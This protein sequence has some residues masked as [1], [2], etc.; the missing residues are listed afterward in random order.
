MT[1][2]QVNLLAR[3]MDFDFNLE[4]DFI[5]VPR[6]YPLL[7]S[8]S[9]PKALGTY[10]FMGK[11]RKLETY[12]LAD[13]LNEVGL[14]CAALYFP[15]YAQYS[16]GP[17]ENKRN[18][19]PEEVVAWILSSFSSVEDLRAGIGELNI[20]NKINAF[21]GIVLPLHWIVSDQSGATIVIEP[22]QEGIKIYDNPIG[23]MTN[24][25]DFN[26]HITNIRNYIGV[27]QNSIRPIKLGGL[28]F[29]PFGSGAGSFG[30]PGDYTPPSRFLRAVFGKETI[31]P[32]EDEDEGVKAAFHILSSVDIPKGNV[33]ADQGVNYTQ[34][35]GCMAGASGN[36]YFKTYDNNQIIKINLFDQDLDAKEPKLYP[37]SQVQNYGSLT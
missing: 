23:V 32:M 4:A 5:V 20:V 3:T 7:T 8:L 2:N 19:S 21:F 18:L 26:W 17:L 36:Y 9:G 31:N 33:I 16:D 24:S 13:G 1:D 28:K 6:N 29:A 11:G 30:L 35:T 22:T 14:A 10:G 27:K 37:V 12:I 34:Y 15:A 25:P